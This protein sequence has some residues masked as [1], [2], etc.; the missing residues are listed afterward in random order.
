MNNV[1][2]KDMLFHQVLF[3]IIPLMRKDGVV[4]SLVSL[5][6]VV[7]FCRMNDLP[8]PGILDGSK[9]HPPFLALVIM[10]LGIQLKTPPAVSFQPSFK[11]DKGTA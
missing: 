2:L 5:F 1:V 11:M 8:L 9:W 3:Y 4:M 10:L 7:D 6:G